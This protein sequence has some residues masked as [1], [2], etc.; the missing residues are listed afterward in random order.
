MNNKITKRESFYLFFL[1]FIGNLVTASG[2]KGKPSGWLLFLI[3]ALLSVPVLILYNCAAKKRMVSRIFIDSLGNK[4]G[5]ILT[6]VYCILS[7]MLAGDSMR[8]FADFIVINDLNDAGAW[9]NAALLTI[10][11]Y[12]LLNCNGKSLGKTAWMLQ[13]I[14]ALM[15]LLSIGLTIPKMEIQRLL[16]LLSEEPS[17]TSK[18]RFIKGG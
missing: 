2:A 18:R 15:L 13:P 17:K 7:V 1:F 9:G 6:G 4:I 8:L 16:P 3:V 12:F 5:G 14:V 10:T 11:V